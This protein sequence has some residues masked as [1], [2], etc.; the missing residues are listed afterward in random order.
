MRVTPGS[1]TLWSVHS[2]QFRW[3]RCLASSTRSWKR[4]S[5][6]FW[7]GSTIALGLRRDD[8]EGEDEVAG[9]VG[10]PDHVPDVDVDGR[11]VLRVRSHVDLLHRDPGFPALQRPL[12]LVGDPPRRA[13][14][15]RGED[16][17]VDGAPE[18]GTHRA[19]P[20]GRAEDEPDRLL[21]LPV[22][23]HQRD[24]TGGP[25]AQR[26][27]PP[28]TDEVLAHVPGSPLS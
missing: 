9:V 23:R 14:G 1:E 5:S 22:P 15:H 25:G 27:G 8:V 20:V 16:V 7:A 6:R 18:L 26:K 10:T 13:A 2:G 28:R 19:L 12:D 24:P 3:T 17:V 21:Y 11:G 4:R